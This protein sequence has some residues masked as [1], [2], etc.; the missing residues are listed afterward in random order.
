MITGK[1][2]TP[3]INNPNDQQQL[4]MI[5]FSKPAQYIKKIQK[6]FRDM[7]AVNTIK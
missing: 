5:A 7:K 2:H 4:L 6:P 1:V 3:S